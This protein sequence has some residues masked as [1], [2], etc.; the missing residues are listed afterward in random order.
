MIYRF[1]CAAAVVS[2]FLT[3][4]PT[5]AEWTSYLN[6]N[7]RAGYTS[8]SVA[9]DLQLAWIRQAPAKPRKAGLVHARS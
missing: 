8:E 7:D 4:T 2:C 5:F 3:V 9:G 6:G 1:F